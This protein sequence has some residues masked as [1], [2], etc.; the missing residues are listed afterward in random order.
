METKEISIASVIDVLEQTAH[1]SLQE[2][3]DNC[4]LITGNPSWKCSGIVCTLDATEAV[5]EEAIEKKCNLIVTHH[6]II[7]NGLKKITG[8][9]YV[10]RTVIKAIKNDIA[11]YAIHTNLDHIHS[12]VNKIIADRLG[13]IDQQ[14]LAPKQH[15]L[16][17][18][19]VF[20]PVDHLEK[21]QAAVFEAGAGHIGHYSECS[22]SVS[23]NGTFKAEEGTKPFAGDIGQRH[24]ASEVKLEVIFPA[25]L[26][27]KV[28]HAI[29]TVHP[30]EEI[31]YDIIQLENSY[32]N[33]GSGLIGKLPEPQ[34]EEKYLH[35]IQEQFGLKT[36]K[37]T[38]FLGKNIQKVAICGGSGSF[39][40]NKTKIAGADLYITA[41]VKYH[42]FFE[43]DG[44]MVLA[45]IGH[46]ET[47]QFTPDL[48]VAILQPKFPTFAVL[49][50]GVNTNPV[51]YFLGD[52]AIQNRKL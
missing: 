10:E 35:F 38:P 45:D 48:L 5:V 6:P 22:F 25:W 52:Q 17:K 39:L 41:D 30:Y 44:Q 3:Y 46:W 16:L 2:S 20:V 29:R 24:T 33:V 27:S 37:H 28:L 49:K 26:Q 14:I 47:E 19:F 18:I 11:I 9:H 7:F 4:G 50:S 13:L 32:Q 12:G 43:A 15:Q 34:N 21:L 8:N 42:E 23:G 40:I 1:P 36:I 31:A 51:N